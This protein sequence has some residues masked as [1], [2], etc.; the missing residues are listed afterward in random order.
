MTAAIWNEIRER[1]GPGP[2]YAR[3]PTMARTPPTVDTPLVETL[4]M[5]MRE[6]GISYR[7]LAAQTRLLDDTGN[8]LS[9]SYLVNLTAGRDL[10]SR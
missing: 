8:G 1:R 6:H 5:L 2:G 9:H 4:P 7:Q 10:P 3:R